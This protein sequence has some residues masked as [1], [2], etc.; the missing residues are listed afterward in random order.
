MAAKRAVVIGAGIVGVAA[1]TYLR[2]DGHDVTLLDMDG[3]GAGASQGNAGCVNGSS[4]VPVAMPGTLAS[5]PRWL[6]DPLGPLAIRWRYL[7][8]LA[9][10]L[11]RF[12]RAGTPERVA[13]Q[14][15]ALRTLLAP[16]V[17]LHR[18]LA[19][20][21]GVPG[22]I[23]RNGHLFAY[24]SDEAFAKD[25]AAM[26][27]RK[28]NGVAVLELGADELRQREPELARD[29][30]RARLIEENGHVGDP[31]AYVRA[32]AEAF[33]REGGRLERRRAV[34]WRVE[35]GRVRA[36]RTDSGEVAGDAFVVA[37]GA[38]SKPLAAALGED[39]PLD[40]ERG[41]H[42]MLRDP[43][44]APRTP[45]MC[46]A[47]KFVVTP[48]DS[49]LRVAG[50]VE[51]AGIAAPPDWRRADAL[52]RQVQAMYPRLAGA[53]REGGFVRWMGFRPSLPDSLPAIGPTRRHPEAILAFGHGHV[54][55]AAGPMTGKLVADLVAGR[56]PGVD[57]APFA[58]ARFA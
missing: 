52:V 54:G 57:P 23:R 12:V 48:M 2:R 44:V 1:A 22:M 38:W 17:D 32:L 26:D 27:L 51:F 55:L 34:G 50:T 16:T 20:D 49:G 24:K 30:L 13:V 28:A 45:T 36:V 6:L 10:W 8:A 43:P 19:R 37:A 3:P 58:P 46:A 21:A 42:V 5:V 11:W 31:L 4:V 18:A 29:Y 41:Y 39:V 47:G 33:V 15:R 25:A 35:D 14:A 7:P 40:T 9:P 56:A 53:F